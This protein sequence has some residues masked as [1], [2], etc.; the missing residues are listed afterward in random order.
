M[1]ELEA[2]IGYT[3]HDT[4]LLATALTHTTFVNESRTSELLLES[5]ERLEFLGDAILQQAVSLELYRI[6]PDL[7][8]GDLTQFRQHLVCEGTLAR[9]ASEIELG[10][11]L[12]LGRGEQG[13]R[14]RPSLLSDALEALFAAV[15]LDSY[16]TDP[17]AAH[18]LILRLMAPEFET[19]KKLRGGD[20]K[21]RMLQ[22]VQGDGEELL[23]YEVVEESGPAHDRLFRVVAR[24][25]SNI[26]GHGTGKTKREAEQ[27]AAKEALILFGMTD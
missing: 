18:Q 9:V 27:N 25:N 22:L 26:V 15:Y 8:E 4:Q 1:T 20:Y 16:L 19:C 11:Y 12:R 24:L 17:Q 10:Q 6:F 3:F 13:A 14:Q 5:N 23:S 2:T 21:T 7:S